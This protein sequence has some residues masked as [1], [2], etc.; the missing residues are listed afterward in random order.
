MP[1]QQTAPRPAP[2]EW[3]ADGLERVERCPVCGEAGRRL[4][5]DGLRDRVFFCAPGT[6]S[7][8]RCAGCGSAYLDP[9]PTPDHIGLAYESYY[10]HEENPAGE[11]PVPTLLGGLRRRLRNGYLASRWGYE[12]E[13]ALAAGAWVARLA[14]LRGALT[15]RYICHL[16]AHPGGRLLDV[17][18][19][20]GAFLAV[21][22]RLGWRAEGVDPDPR[23][24]AVARDA[25][26]TV[27]QGTLA[28]LDDDEHAG[29][30][31]AVTLSHVIEHLHDPAGELA[32]IHRLLA[33]GGWLW[34]GTPNLASLGHRR[35]GEHWRGLEPPRH[36]VLFTPDSLTGLLE[37][38]GFQPEPPPIPSP[39]AA[40]MF[41]ASAAI[42]DGRK[43]DD[44]P[45]RG[46]RRLAALAALANRIA[47]RRPDLAD[48][49]VVLARRV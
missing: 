10:T 22:R 45:P 47:R 49:L 34:I 36:L 20:S 16:P 39:Q 29:A 37:R 18:S 19:G 15:G 17:G 35:F 12:V 33:P 3:P 25:G 24:V 4:L 5:Y 28:D 43:P 27:T 1:V 41:Y 8:F 42:R 48:E 13:P 2:G 38:T 7:L 14:P 40:R 11:D 44:G 30:F 32:R 46:R 26:L 9:R 23:A 6:W 21:M 31:Q